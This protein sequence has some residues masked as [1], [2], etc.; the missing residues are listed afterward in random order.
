MLVINSPTDNPTTT[1]YVIISLVRWTKKKG[2]GENGAPSHKHN[3]SVSCFS[4]SSKIEDF[5][6]TESKEARGEVIEVKL[7]SQD[8]EATLLLLPPPHPPSATIKPS[9]PPKRVGRE[10]YKRLWTLIRLITRQ[11]RRRPAAT[12][13]HHRRRGEELARRRLRSPRRVAVLDMEGEEEDE[14]KRK[15]AGENRTEWMERKI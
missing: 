10:W 7:E 8:E 12:G 2:T 5:P 6:E 4:I 15:G 1:S 14:E 11:D 9:C 3:L 13:Y